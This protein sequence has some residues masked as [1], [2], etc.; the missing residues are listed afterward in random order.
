MKADPDHSLI[1]CPC[2]NKL[3]LDLSSEPASLIHT[4][5]L[6]PSPE[7]RA[8][9]Y[10]LALCPLQVLINR[11]E[12]KLAR[13]SGYDHNKREGL[14]ILRC[15]LEEKLATTFNTDSSYHHFI[16]IGELQFVSAWMG[17]PGWSV[18]V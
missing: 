13:K 9:F 1:P 3:R 16:R 18:Q 17:D 14:A 5:K 4:T 15:F 7:M 8:I 12:L 11:P 6:I 2:T 10:I